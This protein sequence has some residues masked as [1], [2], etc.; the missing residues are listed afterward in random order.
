MVE[1][2]TPF[3]YAERLA[4]FRILNPLLR[5]FEDPMH[6]AH[7]VAAEFLPL[8]APD[9]AQLADA[10]LVEYLRK[11]KAALPAQVVDDPKGAARWTKQSAREQ[12]VLLEDLFWALFSYV[13]SDGPMVVRVFEAAYATELGSRQENA[14]LLLDAEGAQLQ[15]DAAAVWIVIMLE[16]LE[17]ERVAEAGHVQISVEPTGDSLYT[18]SPASLTRLHELIISNSNSHYACV[19]LAWAFVLHRLSV[20]KAQ[21]KEIPAAYQDF[22]RSLPP[23]MERSYAIDADSVHRVMAKRCLDAEAGLFQL[24]Y[25]LL[26]SSPIFVTSV[27]WKTG[28]SVTD[29]NAVAFRSVLKGAPILKN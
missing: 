26:T 11:V 1:L 14:A 24:M 23:K 25:T 22:F 15:Q 13:S 4:L 6:P 29:P 9:G 16:V 17:L 5:A 3:Y 12:L 10:L 19:Y 21:S 20:V 2:I 7:P 18:N 28:S 27:A 8:I